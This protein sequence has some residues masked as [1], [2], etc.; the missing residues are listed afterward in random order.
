M[1]AS[2]L[3]GDFVSRIVSTSSIVVGC[4][5]ASSNVTSS[6]TFTQD[7]QAYGEA[8]P[9]RRLLEMSPASVLAC[10]QQTYVQYTH[11]LRLQR[12]GGAVESTT[13][14]DYH[15]ARLCTSFI[16]EGS[17]VAFISKGSSVAFISKG[18]S[19]AFISKGSSV[20]FISKASLTTTDGNV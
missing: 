2:D 10:N 9:C 3:D 16:S 6:I 7:G 8:V 1:L 17:S 11:D 13:H 5:T 19:V 18:S 14:C 20:S 12:L 4:T 15:Y